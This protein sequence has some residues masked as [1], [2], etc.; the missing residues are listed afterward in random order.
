[1]LSTTSTSHI[2]S[3]SPVYPPAEDS[4]LLLDALSLPSELATVTLGGSVKHDKELW[5][6]DGNIILLAR[7]TVPRICCPTPLRTLASR[8]RRP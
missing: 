5:F 6:D 8:H 1:M 2:P 4:Y 7:D 3:T